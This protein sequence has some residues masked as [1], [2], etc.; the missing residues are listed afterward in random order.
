MTRRHRPCRSVHGHEGE[1]AEKTGELQ[2]ALS[3]E[4]KVEATEES[5]G[6]HQDGLH[7]S[8]LVG[9]ERGDK[10]GLWVARTRTEWHWTVLAARDGQ[11]RHRPS[12]CLYSPFLHTRG[13]K[14]YP[15]GHISRS[16]MDYIFQEK[17]F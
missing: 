10:K 14:P 7:M 17:S 9:R 4:D 1:Y 6:Q 16:Y 3:V 5:K 2:F 12:S 15:A 11:L 13:M 8:D